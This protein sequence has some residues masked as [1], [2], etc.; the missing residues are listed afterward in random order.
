[1]IAEGDSYNRNLSL[2]ANDVSDPS[3]WGGDGGAVHTLS[4][5]VDC[6]IE[7]NYFHN[8]SHGSKCTY[9]DNGSS[10]YNISDHVVDHA[11]SLWLYYQQSCNPTC[12][13]LGPSKYAQPYA[14]CNAT[15]HDKCCCNAGTDNH[16]TRCYIRASLDDPFP[17]QNI[18]S[19]TRVADDAPFPPAAQKIIAAAGPRPVVAA[20][21]IA[22]VTQRVAGRQ[23]AL[24]ICCDVTVAQ[25]STFLPAISA[26]KDN[27]TDV[28]VDTGMTMDRNGTLVPVGKNRRAAL[29]SVAAL[30]AMGLRATA[31][32]PVNPGGARKLMYDSAAAATFVQSVLAEAASS[33][34]AGFNLDAEFPN[35][36]N[37]TDGPH[38]IALLDVLADAL[39][40]QEGGGRTLS[41]DVHGDGSTPFDFHVWGSL[42]R[43][44]KIDHVVTMATYTDAKRNF[45]K[46]F[47]EATLQLGAA[48]YQPGLELNA[49]LSN[50]KDIIYMLSKNVSAIAVWTNPPSGP[51]RQQMWDMMGLFL[52]KEL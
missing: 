12:P 43:S 23:V 24:F 7:R 21:S 30:K 35:D 15:A 22:T 10:G 9:I 40:T 17:I 42:Y 25:W 13:Y 29:K 2:V 41:I 39:H 51:T 18:T 45:D 32:L 37:S 19:L 6:V 46:Y 47:A 14:G 28:I 4:L 27:L 5:C 38:L 31:L 11:N 36:A 3:Y 1:M 49:V 8:Q 16:A 48:I 52:V 44:S 26:H 50:S 33:G 34:V 20:S